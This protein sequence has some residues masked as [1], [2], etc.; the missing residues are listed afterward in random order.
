[1]TLQTSEFNSKASTLL[2]G[3][4]YENEFELVVLYL[5]AGENGGGRVRWVSLLLVVNAGGDVVC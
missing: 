5:K 4:F 3:L 2:G 1:M